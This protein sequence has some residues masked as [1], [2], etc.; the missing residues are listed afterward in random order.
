[1]RL[2]DALRVQRG[3]VVAFIGA[4]GKTSA[5]FR[6]AEELRSDGWRVLATTTTT[7][8]A[9][10][11]ERAP[12][13]AKLSRNTKPAEIRAWLDNHGFVFLHA[14]TDHTKQ[15]I[16]GFHPEVITELVDTVNSDVLL[17][18]ADG[19]SRRSLKA[20]YDHEPVIPADTS[21][22][23]L[24]AG[25]DALGQPLDDDHIYNAER[26]R[27]RYG[28][29]DGGEVLPPWMAVT[30]RDAEL[31]MRGVPEKTRV[32]ALLNKVTANGHERERA[33][34]V[35]QMA[36]R[37]TR[38]EAVALGEM[39]HTGDPVHE[40]QR[41]VGA[42]VLAAGRSARMGRSKVLL[43]WDGRTVIESIVTRLITARIPEIVVVTGYRGGDVA[44]A[45]K[46]LPV[47]TVHNPGYMA[48]EMLSSLQVALGDLAQTTAASLVVLGDQPSLDGRVISR[49]M[50]AYATRQGGIVVPEHRGQRGHPVLF[51]R[52]FWPE[53]LALESGAP[54]DVMRRHPDHIAAVEVESDSILR[55]IDTPEQYRQERLWAG[56]SDK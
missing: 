11:I 38:I 31:G 43:P 41:R 1:M 13:A 15:H 7:L 49:V 39:Q 52:R 42:V 14:G 5:L 45:L 2:R 44:R 22:V 19:A 36:L 56:L 20:P 48:G 25:L 47:R 8:N 55:D 50:D 12:L 18:E 35:A 54:R 10:E 23:V 28:F 32:V 27:E 34:R 40:I 26:I 24:M 21:L 17:I 30:I 46:K 29:P 6:L 16:I 51:D 4:G 37:S 53:L 33:R 9:H 3:D